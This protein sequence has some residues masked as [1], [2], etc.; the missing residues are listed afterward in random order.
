MLLFALFDTFFID[1]TGLLLVCLEEETYLSIAVEPLTVL[2]IARCA[3][4]VTSVIEQEFVE[5]EIILTF[6]RP[7]LII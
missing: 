3:R 6:G 5:E 1:F 7:K 2:P 4:N